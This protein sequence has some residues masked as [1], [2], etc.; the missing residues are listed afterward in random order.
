[1]IW[2]ATLHPAANEMSEWWKAKLALFSFGLKDF[3]TFEDCHTRQLLQPALHGSHENSGFCLLLQNEFCPRYFGGRSLMGCKT[4]IQQLLQ[5]LWDLVDN[6]RR[7]TLHKCQG[8]PKH[9]KWLSEPR[10]S[11]GN[12]CFWNFFWGYPGWTYW[13]LASFGVRLGGWWLKTSCLKLVVEQLLFSGQP[14]KRPQ[15]RARTPN[16]HPR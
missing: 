9:W 10:S 15:K 16:T 12:S 11:T 6:D 8:R 14:P 7:I 3:H 4:A 1:M 13:A 2:R 5:S